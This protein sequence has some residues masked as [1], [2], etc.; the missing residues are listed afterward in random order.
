M[1]DY[2]HYIQAEGD[3]S[4]KNLETDFGN[5]N[6]KYSKCEG[7]NNKGKRKNVYTESFA[8]SDGISVWQGDEVVR[9]ATKITLTLYFIGEER[10][11]MS[12][13]N[14]LYDY[15]KNGRFY[16]WDTA[17][18]KKAYL[19][20]AD[21]FKPSSELWYGGTPYIEAK[22]TLQ[23]LWGECKNCTEDGETNEDNTL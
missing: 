21:E 14:D 2:I 16:Y 1:G 6:V 5:G 13:Y 7:L 22:I 11:R 9:E 19:V 4:P 10:D 23:N 18:L 20:L 15:I 17:R 8:D 3:T 12:A